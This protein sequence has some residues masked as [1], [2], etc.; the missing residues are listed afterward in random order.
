M[1][2]K[3]PFETVP[4]STVTVL[5]DAL[6]AL[7]RV[8][9]LRPLLRHESL[10]IVDGRRDDSRLWFLPLPLK[11][12]VIGLARFYHAHQDLG[13][14]LISTVLVLPREALTTIEM[15]HI[16]RTPAIQN[17]LSDLCFLVAERCN[18]SF[19]FHRVGCANWQEPLATSLPRACNCSVS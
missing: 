5:G 6:R 7:S 10:T 3:S 15:W 11:T 9:I 1:P 4:E 17:N 8:C 19:C 13:R 12:S 2:R 18:F 16:W 14:R